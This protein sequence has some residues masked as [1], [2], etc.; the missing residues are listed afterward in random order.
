MQCAKGK[1][2]KKECCVPAGST[3]SSK[4][5]TL[6]QSHG[7]AVSD[8]SMTLYVNACSPV[9]EVIVL[10][11]P[12]PE[13]IRKSINLFELLHHHTTDTAKEFIVRKPLRDH[14]IKKYYKEGNTYALNL[15][16]DRGETYMYEYLSSCTAKCRGMSVQP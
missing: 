3:Q 2:R 5:M 4:S 10:A 8:E 9:P 14:Q 15:S 16:G 11:S 1:W 13:S 7:V 6:I 12:A